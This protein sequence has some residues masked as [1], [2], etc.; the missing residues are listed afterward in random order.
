[1]LDVRRNQKLE[2][3]KE[4]KMEKVR[5]QEQLIHKRISD[6]ITY[7][8]GVL[9][10]QLNEWSRRVQI[11]LSVDLRTISVPSSTKRMPRSE[12]FYFL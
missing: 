9:G 4:L 2:M 6:S 7:L 11:S 1:M 3:V 5:L 8:D 10:V 12:L